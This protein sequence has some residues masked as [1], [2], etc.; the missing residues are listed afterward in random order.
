MWELYVPSVPAN[1]TASAV[2]AQATPPLIQNE[3]DLPSLA[4]QINAGVNFAITVVNSGLLGSGP[5]NVD[6]KGQNSGN[7]MFSLTVALAV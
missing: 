2:I 3:L 4:A 7:P 5:F 6:V 1:G